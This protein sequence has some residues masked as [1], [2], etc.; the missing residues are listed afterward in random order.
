MNE[1]A[2][3]NKLRGWL[4]IASG[5]GVVLSTTV[6][7]ALRY[8]SSWWMVALLL[9][10]GAYAMAVGGRLLAGEPA[11]RDAWRAVLDLVTAPFW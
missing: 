4:V 5:A 11:R 10:V 9:L 7:V 8:L 3:S 1:A 6:V 2:R